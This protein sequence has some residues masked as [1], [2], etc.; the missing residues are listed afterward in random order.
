MKKQGYPSYFEISGLT[1]DQLRAKTTI[2]VDD[3]TYE[4]SALSWAHRVLNSGLPDDNKNVKLAK[5]LVIYALEAESYN[6]T[7]N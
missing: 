6:G 2:V 5:A 3:K 7:H 1:P 4:F